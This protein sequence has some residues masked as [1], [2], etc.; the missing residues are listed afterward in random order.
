MIKKKN[1]RRVADIISVKFSADKRG[2]YRI[3]YQNRYKVSHG[4]STVLK[5]ASEERA[6]ELF[7]KIF[8]G[9]QKI[10]NT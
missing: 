9:G 4:F 6:K 8:Q 2:R 1:K 7:S 5:T 3:R 10:I